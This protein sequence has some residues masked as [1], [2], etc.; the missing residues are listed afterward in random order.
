[1]N[2]K[3]ELRRSETDVK[4]CGVCGGIGEYLGVDSNVIR[5]IWVAVSLFAGTGILLYIIA[6]VLMPKAQSSQKD[7]KDIIQPEHSS[8]VFPTRNPEADQAQNNL[9]D[10]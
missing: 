3:K 9:Q 6:A 5:L 7:L 2:M 1:M 8:D 10:G 4:I